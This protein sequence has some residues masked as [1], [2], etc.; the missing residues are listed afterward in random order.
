MDV[1]S[2]PCFNSKASALS[3][4]RKSMLTRKATQQIDQHLDAVDRPYP[5][6]PSHCASNRRICSSE[7]S[8]ISA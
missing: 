8:E 6:L 3:L 7:M 4:D 1:V 2:I 5:N